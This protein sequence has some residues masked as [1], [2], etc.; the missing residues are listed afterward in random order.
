MRLTQFIADFNLR[1]G[2]SVATRFH[3]D[4]VVFLG[5]MMNGARYVASD[6]E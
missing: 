5:D 6:D 2:W 3:P 4:V 1:K